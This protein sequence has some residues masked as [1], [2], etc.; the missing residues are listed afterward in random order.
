MKK[1]YGIKEEYIDYKKRIGEY[2]LID[3]GQSVSLIR[4]DEGFFGWGK[5]G[6]WRNTRYMFKKR[7]Y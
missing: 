1:T 5:N 2:A 6:G 3:D 7:M 4:V